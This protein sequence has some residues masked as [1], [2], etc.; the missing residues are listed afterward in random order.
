MESIKDL[1]KMVY[2]RELEYS[3]DLKEQYIQG[4]GTKILFMGKEQQ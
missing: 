2:K 4:N 1:Q 3:G